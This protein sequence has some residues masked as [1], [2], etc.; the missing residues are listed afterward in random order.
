MTK[1]FYNH[2]NKVEKG[3]KR[4]STEAIQTGVV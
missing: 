1:Y 3:Q 2:Q 4:T